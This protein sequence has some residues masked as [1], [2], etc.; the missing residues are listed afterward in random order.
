MADGVE[1]L[2][3]VVGA[4]E[5]NHLQSVVGTGAIAWLVCRR[6]LLKVFVGYLV[7]PVRDL[8]GSILDDGVLVRC[9]EPKFDGATDG[10]RRIAIVSALSTCGV[11]I[12]PYGE[13]A[14]GG[15]FDRSTTG[16]SFGGNTR[17]PAGTSEES[18]HINISI[19]TTGYGVVAK[20]I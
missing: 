13:S 11:D 12:C 15:D 6:G 8:A 10:I 4:I 7:V 1:R 17:T 2:H 3:A 9:I 14:P 5:V 19:G 18:I 20:I 16:S